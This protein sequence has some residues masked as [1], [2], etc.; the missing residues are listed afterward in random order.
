MTE[1]G[2]KR[3]VMLTGDREEI[4]KDVSEKAGIDL[5]YSKLLPDE[6]VTK[7]NELKKDGGLVFY[8]GDGINDA[9]V[10]AAA[11]LGI[12]MG[13]VGSD[14]AIEAADMVIM[15]DSLSKIPK[16]IRIAR[17][18]LRLAKA[19]IIFSLL[20]KAVILIL[21]VFLNREVPMWLAV[22]GDVGVALIAILNSLRALIVKNNKPAK[23][24]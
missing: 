18:T 13:G 8:T 1:L 2:V 5:Y 15:G 14:V 21:V 3:K 6:K 22:F 16:G 9:P 11:D 12:A 10:L 24:E 4:A 23:T 17:K 7:M 19:N 20:V